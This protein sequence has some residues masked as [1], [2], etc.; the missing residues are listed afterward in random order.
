MTDLVLASMSAL[1]GASILAIV[2]LYHGWKRNRQL[3]TDLSAQIAAQR[4]AALSGVGLAP[5]PDQPTEEREPARRKGH[6]LLYIGGGAI[7]AVSVV[8]GYVRS[9]WRGHRVL[10]LTAAATVATV[11]TA[12]AL[13]MT[14]S[15]DGTAEDRGR[16]PAAAPDRNE[17]GT[18][19][20]PDQDAR[21]PRGRAAR[22]TQDGS[23]IPADGVIG[24]MAGSQQR[25]VSS[26]VT[27]EPSAS[28][29]A[30]AGEGSSGG[31]G[32]TKEETSNPLTPATGKPEEPGPGK[33]EPGGPRGPGSPGP[34]TPPE[35]TKPPEPAILTAGKPELADTG[36]RW[37]ESVTVDIYN[38]GGT[39]ATSGTLTF[40]THIIGPLGVDW[41]T[42]RQTRDLPA[43]VPAGGQVEGN[44]TLCVDSWR[45]PMGWRIDTLDVAVTHD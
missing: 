42:I 45:V 38:T 10:A 17:A 44:W 27:P 43:P 23:N 37:C 6:L 28:R 9:L 21:D 40:G 5:S 8:R 41:V 11:G 36:K 31:A 3:I 32:G 7:A 30:P 35:P 26:E 20:V 34:T 39:T 2:L 14:A 19:G 13:V 1:L 16:R 4:I 18:S 15:S 24:L 33:P 29:H 22:G 25:P 12:A